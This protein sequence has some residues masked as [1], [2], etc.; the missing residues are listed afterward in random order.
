MAGAI[1]G[2]KNSADVPP[3]MAKLIKN[4]RADGGYFCEKI[5]A[6]LAGEA[7]AWCCVADVKQKE[8]P[9][10]FIPSIAIVPFLLMKDPADTGSLKAEIIPAKYYS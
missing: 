10:T 4:L 7:D 6:S 1:Q 3:D 2:L 8:L 9:R 5:G